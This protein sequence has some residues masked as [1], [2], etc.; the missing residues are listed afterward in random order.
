MWYA[1]VLKVGLRVVGAWAARRFEGH[2]PSS[3]SGMRP[4]FATDRSRRL[5]LPGGRHVVVPP[6]AAASH[7][8]TAPA[9]YR[10]V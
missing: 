9:A 3:G 4:S 10:C 5:F 2:V 6:F 7:R 8:A 1:L